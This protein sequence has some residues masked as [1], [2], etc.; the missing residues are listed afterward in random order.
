MSA[1]SQNRTITINAPAAPTC[2]AG[3]TGTPPNCKAPTQSNGGGAANPT[4]NPNSSS[5]AAVPAASSEPGDTPADIVS[6]DELSKNFT[7]AETPVEKEP[8]RITSSARW[9]A[10]GAG[11][12]LL[13]AAA[14]IAGFVV[15]KKRFSKSG[16]IIGGAASVSSNLTGPDKPAENKVENKSKGDEGPTIIRPQK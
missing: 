10:I 11:I 3:Q 8:F 6:E 13:L 14:A 9:G 2:P 5:N 4:T 1:S 16:L 12:G 15:Y 7:L